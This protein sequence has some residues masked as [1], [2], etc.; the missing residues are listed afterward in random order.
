[1]ISKKISPRYVPDP[2]EDSFPLKTKSAAPVS[3]NTIPVVLSHVIFSLIIRNEDI[4][5]IIGIMV[6][7]REALIGVEMAKPLKNINWL[8]AIPKMAHNAR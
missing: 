6:M 8:M 1:M 5:T 4:K 7:I 3:P 2:T